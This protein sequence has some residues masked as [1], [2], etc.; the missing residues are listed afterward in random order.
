MLPKSLHSPLSTKYQ[1]LLSD[2]REFFLC[3]ITERSVKPITI[4]INSF[5]AAIQHLYPLQY[6]GAT[7]I[8]FKT[9]SLLC[10]TK[11]VDANRQFQ[12]VESELQSDSK[13]KV[14][15]TPM[16][17]S[18]PSVHYEET[19]ERRELKWMCS[20]WGREHWKSTREMMEATC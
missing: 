19:H 13:T 6:R 20:G 17:P 11:P 8:C 1:D 5:S 4:L 14:S 10:C 2:C 7:N 3:I 16:L 15:G 12:T 9:V 18:F